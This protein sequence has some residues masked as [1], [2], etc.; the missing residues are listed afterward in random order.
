MGKIRKKYDEDFKKNAVKLSYASPK[1]VKEIADDL[2]IHENLCI[3][4]GENIQPMVIRRS[5]PRSKK[6]IE[7]SEENSRKQGWSVIC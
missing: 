6:K 4:G 2:G 5:T 7:R 3:T 1:S